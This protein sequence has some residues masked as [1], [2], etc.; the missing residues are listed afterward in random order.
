V[1]Q[2]LTKRQQRFT[3]I[4]LAVLA[5]AIAVGLVLRALN[6]NISF[7]YSPTQVAKGEAPK[8]KSFRLG[9]MVTEGSV[10]RVPNSLEI[11]FVVTDFAQSVPVRYSGLVPD[12][13]KEGK[14]VVV[15][16]A[17]A[18]DGGFTATEVLAKHDENYMPPEALAAM[19]AAKNSK[20]GK[21]ET[22]PE[23]R[24]ETN[25]ESKKQ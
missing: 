19:K 14:G 4:A 8:N 12:L 1:T 6:S 9:G 20:D 7:F 23:T 2:F 25:S 16:G 13:F 15:Q 24:S 5:L 11:K 3:L 22:K 18:A 17:F 10:V 21:L